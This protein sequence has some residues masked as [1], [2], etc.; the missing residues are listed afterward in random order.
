MHP[1]PNDKPDQITVAGSSKKKQKWRFS[2]FFRVQISENVSLKSVPRST[3]VV[4]GW[5]GMNLDAF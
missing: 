2:F 4:I 3:W 5:I 1:A